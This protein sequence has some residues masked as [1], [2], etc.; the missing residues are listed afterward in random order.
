[1]KIYI[2]KYNYITRR[3]SFV[4]DKFFPNIKCKSPLLDMGEGEIN[5]FLHNFEEVKKLRL[6]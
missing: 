6:E 5:I 1:M 2:I 4:T 3:N